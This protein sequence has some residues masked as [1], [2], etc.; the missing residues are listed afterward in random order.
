MKTTVCALMLLC[1]AFDAHAQPFGAIGGHVRDQTGASLPGVLVDLTSNA[2]VL[3]T[4]TDGQGRFRFDAVPAGKAEL[5]FRSINFSVLRR[6]VAVS[7]EVTATVDATLVLS[8]SAD[9]IVAGASTFRNVA[10]VPDPAASLVGIAAAASQGAVTAAQ[11][12][13]RPVMR[14][15]EVLETARIQQAAGSPARSIV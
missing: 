3:A 15:G 7:V 14:A 1:A 9:V 13:A 12:E 2:R 10:D 6:T 4:T 8:L 5:T 11:L